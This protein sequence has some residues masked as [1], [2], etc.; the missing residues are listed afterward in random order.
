MKIKYFMSSNK[1]KKNITILLLLLSC[2]LYS[3]I[4]E[5]NELSK[6]SNGERKKFS[7]KN[8]P[9]A[10]GINM[11]INYPS[12]WKVDSNRDRPNMVC[13][14]SKNNVDLNITS[15]IAIHIINRQKDLIKFSDKEIIDSY[16]DEVES[17]VPEEFKVVFKKKTKIDGQPTLMYEYYG[18]TSRA[19]LDF[20]T[21]FLVYTIPYNDK[22]INVLFSCGGLANDQSVESI[23]NNYKP[24]FFKMAL[25]I[26]F[27]DKWK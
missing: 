9:K 11:T 15:G 12:E 4:L 13:L 26:I 2:V 20:Q 19:G 14:I 16:Y 6:Y 23:Y 27:P 25:S 7:T 21:F 18:E 10:K 22:M 5:L 1:L 24:L 8:H 17:L 3:D